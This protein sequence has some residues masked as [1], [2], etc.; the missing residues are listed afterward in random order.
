MLRV[1]LDDRSSAGTAPG[2]VAIDQ[3]LLESAFE[4]FNTLKKK[5]G[6]N[7]LRVALEEMG[8]RLSL[9]ELATAL[10]TLG[11]TWGRPTQR[12]V[13]KVRYPIACVIM[14]IR[15]CTPQPLQLAFPHLYL[16]C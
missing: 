7:Q 9:K 12:Q 13:R 8:L 10:T 2:T 16:L 14:N 15:H 6:I 3:R 5:E 1:G 11:L 4:R